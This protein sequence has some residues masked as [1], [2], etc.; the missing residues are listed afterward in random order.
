MLI[1]YQEVFPEVIWALT[2]S[3]EGDWHHSLANLLIGWFLS[4]ELSCVSLIPQASPPLIVPPILSSGS[5]NGCSVFALG[6]SV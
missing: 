1:I 5:E 2:S 3:P 4:P 6:F